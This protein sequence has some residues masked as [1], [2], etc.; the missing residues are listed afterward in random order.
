MHEKNL[1]IWMGDG[2]DFSKIELISK[3][4][5]LMISHT[6]NVLWSDRCMKL[7]DGMGTKRVYQKMTRLTT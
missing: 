3:L 2:K 5:Q 6:S 1:L 7:V 4:R